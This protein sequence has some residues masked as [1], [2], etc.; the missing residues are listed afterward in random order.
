MNVGKGRCPKCGYIFE[1]ATNLE[2]ERLKPR[3]G[4]I[5]FCIKCGNV[6]QYDEVGVIPLDETKLDPTT[7]IEILKIREAWEW[8]KE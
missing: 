2:D 6:N 4:D 7:K 5:S 3:I 8:M 1:L